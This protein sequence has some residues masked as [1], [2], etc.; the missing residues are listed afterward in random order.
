MSS[1]ISA[2]L[3]LWDQGKKV[4]PKPTLDLLYLYLQAL[5]QEVQCDSLHFNEQ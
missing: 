2:L 5:T 4:K 3:H 1:A